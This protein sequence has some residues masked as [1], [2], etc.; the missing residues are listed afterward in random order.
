MIARFEYSDHV[1]DIVETFTIPR[2][3]RGYSVS[4]IASILNLS[5]QAQMMAMSGYGKLKPLRS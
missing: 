1:K 3:C 4:S 2:E 5:Y